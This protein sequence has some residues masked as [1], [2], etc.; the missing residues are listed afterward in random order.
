MSE[1]SKDDVVALM[2][3]AGITWG[4]AASVYAHFRENPIAPSEG[5]I[6]EAEE[7]DLPVAQPHACYCC[8]DNGCQWGC[9]CSSL[10]PVEATGNSVEMIYEANLWEKHSTEEN[11]F[12]VDYLT[13]RVMDE[14]QFSA[15]LNEFLNEISPKVEATGSETPTELKRFDP[16]DE[17]WMKQAI[18]G[19]WVRFSIIAPMNSMLEQAMPF[20]KC[21]SGCDCEGDRLYMKIKEFL[22]L[23]P[24]SET[25]G[26]K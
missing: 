14:Y 5:L 12:P 22:R 20:L 10:A 7:N 17:G 1:V 2:K 19:D 18:D 21:D 6:K 11:I 24:P 15:A 8:R 4:Q 25:K 16:D 3:A 13:R 26:T 23:S 9:K